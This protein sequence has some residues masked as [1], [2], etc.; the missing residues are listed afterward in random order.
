[1]LLLSWWG[2]CVLPLCV[3]VF[4]YSVCLS[5][6]AWPSNSPSY[7]FTAHPCLITLHRMWLATRLFRLHCANHAAVFVRSCMF[8][9]PQQ[10]LCLSFV[11]VYPD[12]NLSAMALLHQSI[13]E[14]RHYSELNKT[15]SGNIMSI[16]T[17]V[18]VHHSTCTALSVRLQG[19]NPNGLLC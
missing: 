18:E 3:C 8:T 9:E 4:C 14:H 2:F 13:T 19:H 11:S 15:P 1:M 16:S 6:W 7:L 12:Q 17:S 10:R 5:V